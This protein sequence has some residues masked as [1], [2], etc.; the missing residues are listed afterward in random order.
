MFYDNPPSIIATLKDMRER[1]KTPPMSV[2]EFF[3]RLVKNRLTMTARHLA[4]Y[5]DLL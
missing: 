2:E 4:R 5:R 1:F 3:E